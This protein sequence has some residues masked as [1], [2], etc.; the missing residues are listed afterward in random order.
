M[1]ALDA[2]L[3]DNHKN[4][5]FDCRFHD[6]PV[7]CESADK[8]DG[9][10]E[11]Y[12]DASNETIYSSTVD[13]HPNDPLGSLWEADGPSAKAK[14]H[15]IHA[16]LMDLLKPLFSEMAIYDPRG[17]INPPSGL[18][19]GVW[20]RPNFDYPLGHGY[21]APTKVRYEPTM[22]GTPDKACGV[23]GLTDITYR[24]RVLQPWGTSFRGAS[25]FLAN[26]DWI[27]SS[28]RDYQGDWAEESLLQAERAM[29]LLGTPKPWWLDEFYYKAKIESKVS[30]NFVVGGRDRISAKKLGSDH[31]EWFSF[32]VVGIVVSL[33][34]GWYRRKLICKRSSYT[35]I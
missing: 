35:P 9:W 14:L 22:S 29:L 34:V 13:T 25:L 4:F 8:C 19:V 28:A 5:P 2:T 24:D 31:V 3:A 6:G 11:I 20:N 17:S 16:G 30:G 21:T 18:L 33:G 32:V 7:S 10:L 26:N 1:L 12:Y 27:C 23:P 15:H